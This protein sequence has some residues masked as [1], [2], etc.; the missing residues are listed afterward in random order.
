VNKTFFDGCR[1][2]VVDD[3]AT[4]MGTKQDLLKTVEQEAKARKLSVRLTG[5][6]IAIDREQTTAVYDPQG[7]VVPGKKGKNAIQDFVVSTGI[8]VYSVTGIREVVEFLYQASVPVKVEGLF[9]PIDVK[10]KQEF[11]EYLK[12]YG[13]E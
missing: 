4:S 7:H 10:T 13:V 5:I 8:P 11:D 2:F 9:A 12:T 6:G 3:V 1:V